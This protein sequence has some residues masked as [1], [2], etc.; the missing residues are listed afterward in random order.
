MQSSSISAV[1]LDQLSTGELI[2]VLQ[3]NISKNRLKTIERDSPLL[4]MKE[5]DL[6]QL[7]KSEVL[8][9]EILDSYFLSESITK[10]DD[11]FH[12]QQEKYP[13]A[14]IEFRSWFSWS[15]IKNSL[16]SNPGI[17]GI[18]TALFGSLWIIVIT[19]LIAFPLGLGAAVYL[20][21]YAVNNWLN[22]IIKTNI[23]NL[24]GVPSIVYG[25]LG[26]AV[27]VRGSQSINKRC[28]FWN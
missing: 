13:E 11:I 4:M 10:K 5:S 22:R 1:P 8:K 23:D 6:I 26:L 12:L 3:D 2:R 18:R 16:S 24:A 14:T 28:H 27:F 17:A 21:E 19:I 9:P 25:M 7:I 15:F 20:E